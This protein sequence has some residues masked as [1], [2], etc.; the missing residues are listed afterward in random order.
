M[1]YNV[2]FISSV[3]LAFACIFAYSK[4]LQEDSAS[5]NA[6]QLEYENGLDL[7]RRITRQ[8][9]PGNGNNGN[10]NTSKFTQLCYVPRIQVYYSLISLDTVLLQNLAVMHVMCLCVCI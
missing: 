1:K 6:A 5:S 3:I 7:L 8:A 4:P 9:V 10:G 2:I